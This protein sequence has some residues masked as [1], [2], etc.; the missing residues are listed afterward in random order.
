MVERNQATDRHQQGKNTAVALQ[1]KPQL[2]KVP[3]YELDLVILSRRIGKL[4]SPQE[5]SAQSVFDICPLLVSPP[6]YY[7]YK[8]QQNTHTK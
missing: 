8:Y 1:S 4:Q 3:Q 7:K 6:Q 5:I 2:L